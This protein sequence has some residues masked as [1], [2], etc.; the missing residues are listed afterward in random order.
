VPLE[1]A[2]NIE[3]KADAKDVVLEG[4]PANEMAQQILHSSK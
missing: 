3:P 4:L 2:P 1:Q